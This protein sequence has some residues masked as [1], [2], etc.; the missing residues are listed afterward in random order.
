MLSEITTR[1]MVNSQHQ[2]LSH[3]FH[4]EHVK[5]VVGVSMGGMQVFQW[6]V[7]YPDF[8]DK[9]IS[10]IGSPQ[11][12]P[13]DLMLYSAELHALEQAGDLRVEG[14]AVKSAM[15]T[16]A[17]IQTIAATTPEALNKA[18]D[19]DSFSE[20]LE[21]RE[22]ETFRHFKASDWLA[23]LQAVISHNIASGRFGGV[24]DRAAAVVKTRMLIV[25]AADDHMV[26]PDPALAFA[27]MTHSQTLV[28]AEGCDHVAF[29]CQKELGDLNGSTQHSAR[30]HL[31]LKTKAKIAR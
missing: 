29:V 22:Q 14:E 26:N 9:A 28:L 6:V 23:Q 20:F 2:L 30:T 24:L 11:P 27:K 17:D 18:T 4:T 25:V 31:A 15:R 13:Y 7:S 10:I 1:D 16:V 21:Q 5:A 12:T 3:E 8:M 19:R